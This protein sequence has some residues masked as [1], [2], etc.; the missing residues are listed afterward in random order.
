MST[1]AASGLLALADRLRLLAAPDQGPIAPVQPVTI[2]AALPVAASWP[3]CPLCNGSTLDHACDPDAT[4]AAL[5]A[6]LR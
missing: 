3:R 2:T 4:L 1:P 6:R 5:L